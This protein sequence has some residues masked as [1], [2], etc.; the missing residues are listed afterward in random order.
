MG[1]PLKIVLEEGI[2]EE[3]N[4]SDC[5]YIYVIKNQAQFLDLLRKVLNSARLTEIVTRHIQVY[6]N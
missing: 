3:I 5:G 2:A 1:Y 6:N 4:D